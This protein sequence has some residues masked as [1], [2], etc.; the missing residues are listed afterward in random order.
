VATPQGA[1]PSPWP[2]PPMMRPPGP[3]PDDAPSPSHLD[4]K[5]L[6]DGSLFPETYCKPPPSK[7]DREDPGALLGTLLERG[8][9]IGG[10]LQ[11]HGR[12]QSDV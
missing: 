7:R 3:P 1:Q 12:L 11:H 9:P 8:I 2:R 5:N 6:W 10:L 4:G